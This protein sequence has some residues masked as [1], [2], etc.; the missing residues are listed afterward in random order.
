MSS[1]LVMVLSQRLL[2]DPCVFV[3]AAPTCRCRVWCGWKYFENLSL[4]T[5]LVS[6]RKDACLESCQVTL[7]SKC[8]LIEARELGFFDFVWADFKFQLR[9]IAKQH[10]FSSKLSSNL[11]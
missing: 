11:L 2:A 4:V 6:R 5:A 10:A 7:S 3:F 9:I 1:N 8:E